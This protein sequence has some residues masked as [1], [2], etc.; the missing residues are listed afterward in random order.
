MYQ[1]LEPFGAN[2]NN[3]CPFDRRVLFPKLAPL[4]NTEGIE[5]RVELLDW[6]T[7]TQ[8]WQLQV[9]N[10]RL[11]AK[12]KAAMNATLV[13]RRLGEAIEELELDVLR[14]EILMSE[15]NFS[16]RVGQMNAAAPHSGGLKNIRHRLS[17]IMTITESLEGHER[18]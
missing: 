10:R 8:N 2:N 13:E 1:W 4:F 16:N 6:L 3:T 12:L 5:Q 18:L 17:I 14:A 11:I 9:A 15:S 7:A